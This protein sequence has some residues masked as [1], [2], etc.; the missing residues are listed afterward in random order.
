M[1]V[2]SPPQRQTP[3]FESCLN[4]RVSQRCPE[5]L[6]NLWFGPAQ[7]TLNTR[8]PSP[9]A[10]LSDRS[11]GSREKCPL[12][13]LITALRLPFAVT[14]SRGE[15]DKSKAMFHLC[16]LG[17]SNSEGSKRIETA[18]YYNEEILMLPFLPRFSLLASFCSCV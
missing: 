2:M 18:C 12:G 6:L 7:L 10:C 9:A 14:V 16:C 8:V 17:I 3:H 11:G 13:V 1:R 15:Q 4:T 5:F